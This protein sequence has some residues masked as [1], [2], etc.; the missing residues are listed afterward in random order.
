[1]SDENIRNLERR[2]RAAFDDSVE[3]VDGATRARLARM[4][5]AA[6]ESRRGR[7]VGAAAWLPAGVAA[8]AVAAAVLWQREEAAPRQAPPAIALEDLD[9]VAGGEDFDLLAEDADFVA[10]AAA[11]AGEG[12]G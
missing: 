9:I 4:R 7:R 5:A 11:A 6:L 3:A 10:W 1:M 12:I 8:A 2:S